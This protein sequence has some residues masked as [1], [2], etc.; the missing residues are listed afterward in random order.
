MNILVG[1]LL[2]KRKKRK[3][4]REKRKVVLDKVIE[5]DLISSRLKNTNK[6]LF[7]YGIQVIKFHVNYQLRKYTLNIGERKKKRYN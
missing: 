4:S 5:L 6:F 2:E 1:I 3:Q 7:S